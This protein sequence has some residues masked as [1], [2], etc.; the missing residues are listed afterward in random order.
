MAFTASVV[1]LFVASDVELKPASVPTFVAA[2]SSS[3]GTAMLLQDCTGS[4]NVAAHL[5]D[6]DCVG[7][8]SYNLLSQ[9]VLSFAANIELPKLHQY[10]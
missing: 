8:S 3:K 5:G 4:P 6:T 7:A 1:G 9:D 2:L 10:Q